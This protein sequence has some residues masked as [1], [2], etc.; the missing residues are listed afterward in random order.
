MTAVEVNILRVVVSN[1]PL[2]VL[3]VALVALV[4]LG[5]VT[6]VPRSDVLMPSTS[7]PETKAAPAP[8]VASTVPQQPTSTPMSTIAPTPPPP[9]PTATVAAIPTSTVAPQPTREP[10]TPAPT[11]PPTPATPTESP[12]GLPLQVYAPEDGVTVPGSSVVVYGQTLPGIRVFVAGDE[13]DVDSQG[14]FRVS[15]PLAPSENEVLIMAEDDAGR[16]TRI[17]RRVTS[18]ALP[19]LLLITEPENETVVSA[20][21]LPLSGR[22]GP[23][24][25]VSI[26]GRS[27]PVDRFGYFTSTVLLEEGPNVMDVVA[28]NDDGQTLSTVLAVIYRS[29][30]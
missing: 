11:L 23:N 19:F 30:G 20:A 6:R 17:S 1:R 2:K 24:A 10:S 15:V 3:A 12:N 22:T 27:V 21:V 4:L 18:L 16:E 5:C 29:P 13:T 14:G 26:N 28:T 8:T 25:I 7:A 9:R